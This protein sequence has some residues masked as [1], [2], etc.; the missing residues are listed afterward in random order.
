M[1]KPLALIVE[2]DMYLNQIYAKALAG[3][4][5]TEIASDGSTALMRLA[6][7]I[8]AVIILDLNLPGLGGKDI[9]ADIRSNPNL[10]QTHVIL[11]T[12]DSHQAAYLQEQADI[13]MLKPV[14]PSQL[15]QIATRFL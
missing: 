1:K 2:D 15:R 14:S 3:E 9:L 4:F 7:I 6:Q 10:T 12:A 8:P 5:E 11:C 13:V